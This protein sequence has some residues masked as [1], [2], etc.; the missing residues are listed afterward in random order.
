[1]LGFIGI[2]LC[3]LFSKNLTGV[4][5]GEPGVDYP[6]YSTAP[7]TAFS[8]EGRLDGLYGDLEADCQDLSVTLTE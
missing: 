4:F 3:D 6:I 7:D 2:K 5:A 8:C 1:M